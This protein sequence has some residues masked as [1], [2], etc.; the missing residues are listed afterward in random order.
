MLGPIQLVDG[1]LA[2]GSQR[3]TVPAERGPRSQYLGRLHVGGPRGTLGQEVSIWHKVN[4]E[5]KMGN[6]FLNDL[7]DLDL[8][9]RRKKKKKPEDQLVR[10]VRLRCPKCNSPNVPVYDSSHLPIRYHKCSNCGHTFKSIE[11]NYQP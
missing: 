11:E 10:Y 7:P 2:G 6:G 1:L 8:P 5:V 3:G 9:A 4:T